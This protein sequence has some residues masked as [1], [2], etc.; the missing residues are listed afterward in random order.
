MREKLR[1]DSGQIPGTGSF[2]S[3]EQREKL[4]K[5]VFGKEFGE[6]ISPDEF[7]RAIK[8]LRKQE[9]MAKTGE[10]KREIDRKVRYLEKLREEQK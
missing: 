7:K 5:E 10:E 4:E 8:K 1:K 6:Y 2:Y 9:F 3:R